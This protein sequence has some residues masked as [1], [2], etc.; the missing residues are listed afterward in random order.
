LLLQG[1]LILHICYY[2]HYWLRQTT[3]GYM[4][5]LTPRMFQ[6][7]IHILGYCHLFIQCSVVTTWL[8]IFMFSIVGIFCYICRASVWHK[9]I[10]RKVHIHSWPYCYMPLCMSLHLP[11]ITIRLF[12]F[13]F[14]STSPL[15]AV[16]PV[17]CHIGS[18][19]LLAAD[20]SYCPSTNASS[21]AT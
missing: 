13:F 16:I 14:F 4:L 1:W 19:I 2:C 9:K 3:P 21:L 6:N 11:I 20:I 10:C 12:F 15:C 17:G 5:I 8:P 7:R 18:A